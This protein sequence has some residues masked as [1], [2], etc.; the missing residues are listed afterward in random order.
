MKRILLLNAQAVQTLIIAESLHK[1]GYSVDVLCDG[2]CN[3]GYYTRY[4]NKRFVGPSSEDE[5]QYV[6]FLI[7]LLKQESYA[8]VIPM[9][10]PVAVIT[11][12]YKAEL[13]HYTSIL[14]PDYDTFRKAYDKHQLMQ[15]C[16]DK[17]YPHPRTIGLD[18]VCF[19]AIP[20]D[21]FPALIK[22]NC[23][24][25]GRG[26]VLVNSMEELK[27]KVPTIIRNYGASHLQEFIQPGGRQ[28]KVQIFLSK[29]G[30]FYSSVIH[31]QRFYPEN[32]GSSCCNMT[33]EDTS[34]AHLC[35][36]ILDDIGWYGFADFDLIEDP[37]D[38]VCKVME[39]NPRI[40]ACIKSAVLSGLDYGTMIADEALGI[41]QK[42][43]EYRP[44]EKLRHIGLDTL[45]FLYSKNRFRSH[46]SWFRWIDTNLSF[47]D[48]SW[49]DPLPFICGTIGNIKKQMSPSFREAKEG[50]R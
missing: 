25:G 49:S 6:A 29:T 10:D 21:I 23:T 26:M 22:P 13:S 45:W 14:M 9:D 12:K 38:G 44:G 18:G 39:I 3:Y 20:D 42:E 37:K 16:Q 46:P 35:K 48:F 27:S 5:S 8:S 1:S 15:L 31:K 24:S 47:Q 30:A 19:E 11:S 7:K 43:Y 2:K 50:L 33:I 28:L 4:A 40:P 36:Q 41:M 32:G 34:L 17:G